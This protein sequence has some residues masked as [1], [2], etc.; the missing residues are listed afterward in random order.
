MPGIDEDYLERLRALP[1]EGVLPRL[2][3]TPPRHTRGKPFL[4]RCTAPETPY[5]PRRR[6]KSPSLR[7]E[8][9]GRFRCYSCGAGGDV[10]AFVLRRLAT[11]GHHS[12]RDGPHPPVTARPKAY[13]VAR[14]FFRTEFG[15]AAP[16]RPTADAGEPGPA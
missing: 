13:R 3:I 1:W 11:G 14:R 2:G 4:M 5:F 8:P 9:N 6:E 15:V 7:F 12:R 10:F 16:S